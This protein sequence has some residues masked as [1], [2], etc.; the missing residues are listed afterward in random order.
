MPGNPT[1][2]ALGLEIVQWDKPVSLY[3]WTAPYC[4][5]QYY[6]ISQAIGPYN[7]CYNSPFAA[8]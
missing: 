4:I 2:N 5:G 7:T 6:V 8:R 1:N 3:V